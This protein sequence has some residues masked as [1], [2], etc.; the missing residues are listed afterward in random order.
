[1]YCSTGML[2]KTSADRSTVHQIGSIEHSK[3]AEL[4]IVESL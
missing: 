4:H 3:Q 1:M 2:F